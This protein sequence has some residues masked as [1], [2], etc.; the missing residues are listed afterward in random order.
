[1]PQDFKRFVDHVI[2]EG[3]N[4]TED[5]GIKAIM[6]EVAKCG[7]SEMSDEYYM[8]TKLFAKPSNRSFFLS[9]KTKEGKLNWLKRQF[10]DRKRN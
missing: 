3:S 8:A 6:E 10:E 2:S 9:M 7:A 4:T 1:V 5:S